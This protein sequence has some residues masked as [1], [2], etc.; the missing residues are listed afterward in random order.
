MSNQVTPTA[1]THLSSAVDLKTPMMDQLREQTQQLHQQ[2]ED[3]PFNQALLN[4]C[5]PIALYQGLL[6]ALYDLHQLLEQHCAHHSHPA[7]QAVWQ[8][9]LIKTHILAQD[10]AYL[11]TQYLTPQPPTPLTTLKFLATFNTIESSGTIEPWQLLGTLYVLEGS[12]LGAQVLLPHLQ[13]TYGLQQQGLLYYH[14]Y[15]ENTLKHWQD[16]KTRMN[17]AIQAPPDQ[18]A[19]LTSAEQTFWYY[20]NLLTELWERQ[21]D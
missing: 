13:M 5:L 12:T 15:G 11:N 16:F 21:N 7:V 6:T 9:D 1:S 8:A 14:A 2:L 18:Q 19:V 4:H 3:H 17:T 20:Q 10:I